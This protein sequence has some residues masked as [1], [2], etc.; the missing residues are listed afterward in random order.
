[1][2]KSFVYA[3]I[4]AS[5]F[6]LPAC[7]KEYEGDDDAA[8]FKTD[9]FNDFWW[10]KQ[11]PVFI[12]ATINTEFEECENLSGPLV[13]QL[14]DDSK[15]AIPV[16]TAQLYVNDQLS[17]N[18]TISIDPKAGIKET[19]I[20]IV[21]NPNQIKETRTF[22]WN[23]QVVDAAEIERINDMSP[24][25][26]NWIPNTTVYW[27]NKHIANPLRVGV[28][29]SLFTIIA[30]FLIILLI[31][32]ARI[33]KFKVPII[34]IDDTVDRKDSITITSPRKYAKIVLTSVPGKKQ[35]GF[36]ALFVGKTKYE[37]VEGAKWTSDV[38]LT[39]KGGSGADAAVNAYSSDSEYSFNEKGESIIMTHPNKAKSKITW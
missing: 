18:N 2:K 20:K 3:I 34:D 21:L 23:L 14:C 29:S 5:L 38:I 4:I 16:S 28:D 37:Y 33:K 12:E 8:I 26:Q 6:T 17:Q 22:T 10:V 1:M 31:C 24:D 15:N 9:A 36:A 32:Q 30:A 11:D 7:N 19:Q 39:P 35:S 27:K 13:L 25:K